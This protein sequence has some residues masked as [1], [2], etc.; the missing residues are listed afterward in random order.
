MF[1]RARLREGAQSLSACFDQVSC[2]LRAFQG[3]LDRLD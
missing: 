3:F 1:D 2:D